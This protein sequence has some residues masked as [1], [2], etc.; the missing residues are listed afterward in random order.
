MSEKKFFDYIT[1]LKFV[2]ILMIT[3]SH[4]KWMYPDSLQSLACGGAWG[5]A[6]FFFCSGFTMANIRTDCFWKYLLKRVVRIYPVIWIWYL[7][8][9]SI[10]EDFT[11]KYMLWPKYWF[12]Q[13][14]LTFYV[15]FYFC[16]KWLKPFISLVILGCLIAAATIY[17]YADHSA[18]MID[19][20]YQKD[21]ITWYYYFGLMLFGA[22]LRLRMSRE[23]K[24]GCS[25]FRIFIIPLSF[26]ACY[27]VKLVCLK[28]IAPS[29]LQ[30]LFPIMLY[31]SCFLFYQLLESLSLNK[32]TKLFG[33]ISFI[34]ERTLE[35]YI[36][37]GLILYICQ[38]MDRPF[39]AIV[40]VIAIL[41]LSTLFHW[42]VAKGIE[43]TGI[44]RL[45]SYK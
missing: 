26:V 37:Q 38:T 39:G 9:F 15:F 24:E 31:L 44:A 29:N 41:A 30:L 4:S 17:Y 13:A 22:F 45:Y 2:A 34:S 16:M 5:C 42:L 28:E 21:K 33:G 27:G 11:W 6:I 25:T 23:K 7:L 8:T 12:I 36:T 1:L 3:N 18:W 14:I 19:L 10:Q 32:K 35:I 43:K 20:T 40:A